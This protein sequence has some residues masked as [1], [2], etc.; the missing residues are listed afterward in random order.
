M[1]AP[2][3][4]PSAAATKFERATPESQGVDSSAI[5][6]FIEGANAR[7]YAFHSL[8]VLRHGRVIAEGWWAPYRADEPHMMFSV[9]KSITATAIGMLIDEGRA[10]LD[11]EMI[12]VFPHLATPTARANARGL[13]L[14]HV[15]AM[16]TGHAVDTMVIM[17]A[18]PHED[19]V[20]VFFGV[21]IEYPP[22]THFLYNSGASFVLA[23]MVAARTGQ[24]VRD[25]LEPR[26]FRPLGIVDAPWEKNP[27]GINFGASGLRLTTEDLAKMGQLYLNRGLWGGQRILSEQWVDDASAVHVSNAPDPNIDS[28][29]GY[30]FQIWRSRHNSYRMTGRYGQFAFV[31]PEQ[32]AVIA[33]TAGYAESRTVPNLVWDTLLPAMQAKPLPENPAALARLKGLLAAQ[34]VPLPTFLAAD[35]PLAAKIHRRKVALPFNLVGAT[36]LELTFS[37]EAIDLAVQRRDGG[38]ESY[39]AGRKTWMPGTTHMWPYEEMTQAALRSRA[40]WT[41][42]RT[43][44]IRQ[45]CVETPFSRNW[46]LEF[47]NSDQVTVSV[48]LDNGFWVERTEVLSGVIS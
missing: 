22:G 1:N 14:R 4:R 46:K 20:K 18:L 32:D 19:W 35:P 5:V 13:K 44:E 41:D 31:L 15:L 7:K 2:I 10:H 21:P 3:A 39:P 38:T 42:A 33:I 29:Q 9:S 30:G 48:G 24:S 27:H 16:A 47:N 26:L 40:G 25:Y 36:S 34:E 45:Q 43:L 6:A 17:R 37:P 12:E 23:A 11:E 8:M 28:A